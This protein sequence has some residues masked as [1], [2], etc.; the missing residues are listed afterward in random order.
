MKRIA[1]L[2]SMMVLL[3]VGVAEAHF[4]GIIPSTDIVTAEGNKNITLD[5]LFFHPFAGPLMNME[6]PVQF[7]VLA[8]GKKTNLLDSLVPVKKGGYS[9]FRADYKIKRPGDHV[10]YV[11]PSPYWEPSEDTFIVHYTKVVVNAMGLELGWDAE[12]GLKA[13]IVPLVRP[14][15]LWTGN[16]FRGI[17][18]LDGKP[19]PYAEIEVE[20]YNKGG[21][22]TAPSGPFVTQVIKADGNGVFAYAMPR[23]GWWA[24][25]A[26]SESDKTMKGPDGKDKPI[27]IGALMW[28]HVTD[29]K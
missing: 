11:E 12:V 10:F 28:V 27:E 24:F 29:M 25:A 3:A 21:K 13:E 1:V 18:K 20:Y 6:K 23:A 14:Y 19:V 16:L 5:I 26:L 4:Q 2:A 7:G 15:G 9:T 17:V 22:I 8:R